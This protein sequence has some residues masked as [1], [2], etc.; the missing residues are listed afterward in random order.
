MAADLA[1]DR[2][3]TLRYLGW[4]GQ[5]LTPEMEER[6]EKMTALAKRSADP[7]WTWQRFDFEASPEGVRLLGTGVTFRGGDLAAHLEGAKAL[8]VLAVTLGHGVER[9]LLRLQSSSMSDAII[10]NAA[11]IALT[12]AAGDACQREVQEAQDGLYVNGR[13]SPGYGDFPLEQQR[14]LLALLSAEERLGITLTDGLLMLP[15]KSV[16]SVVGLFPEDRGREPGCRVCAMRG[17]CEFRRTGE[18]CG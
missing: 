2:R 5:E 14:E 4:R 6:I 16:T 8:A 15:R 11:S 18:H 12:E 1:L 9:T 10:Y 13:Y 7:K 3:E 17:F